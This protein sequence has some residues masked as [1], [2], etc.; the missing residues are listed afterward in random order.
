MRVE[1]SSTPRVVRPSSTCC[2]RSSL[3]CPPET[4]S[5]CVSAH[6]LARERSRVQRDGAPRSPPPAAPLRSPSPRRAGAR[7]RP[8]VSSSARHPADTSHPLGDTH[9]ARPA[10]S[11]PRSAR[12]RADRPPSPSRSVERADPS[13]SASL[14]DTSHPLGDTHA[15]RPAHSAPRSARRRPPTADRP[16]LVARLAA[17]LLHGR[18]VARPEHQRAAGRATRTPVPCPAPA[19]VPVPRHAAGG[20]SRRRTCRRGRN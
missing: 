19:R 14:A 10:H 20:R 13:R 11:A 17:R 18:Q 8:P 7:A 12:P 3:M 6:I 15:A 2:R 5:S 1:P 4:S 16:L 9:A